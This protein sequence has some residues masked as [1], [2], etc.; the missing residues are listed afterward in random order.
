MPPSLYVAY[1]TSS[2][3][4]NGTETEVFVNT[5]KTLDGETLDFSNFSPFTR[6]II[7]ADPENQ[8]SQPE[9]IS[10]TGIDSTILAF[11]GITRGL[12]SINSS[13]IAANKVYHGTGTPV[14]ISWGAQNI[15]DLIA[16]VNGLVSGVNGNASNTVFGI[17]KLNKN[18]G[19]LPRAQASLVSQ[20]TSPNLTLKVSAFSM[21]G[22]NSMNVIYAGG[23][24]STITSPASNPRI[25][26]VV[27]NTDT[28]TLLLRTGVE[29]SSPLRPT[30]TTNDIVLAAIYNRVGETSIKENDDSTNGYILDWYEPSRFNTLINLNTAQATL[31]PDQNQS[32]Q[33]SSV[34]V[35][36]S[37]STTHKSILA[38]SFLPTT[39]GISAVKLFKYAD[40]GTF[41]GSVKVSIQ[42]S[43]SGSPSGT[44][45]ASYTISNAAWLKLN[46]SAEFTVSFSTE[47][48]SLSVGSVYWIVIT[49]STSDTSN[50]PNLGINTA[51]GYAGSLKYNNS[52]DGWIL[53]STSQLY[54]KEISGIV[55]KI[56]Q[57]DSTGLTP[58]NVRPYSLVSFDKTT[59]NIATTNA[60]TVLSKQL[61]GGFFGINTGIKIR[62]FGNISSTNTSTSSNLNILLK[63][64]G[65]SLSSITTGN[66]ENNSNGITGRNFYVDF[67]IVNQN[68][69]SSQVNIAQTQETATGVNGTGSAANLQDVANFSSG[70]STIDTSQPGLLE[71]IF[72]LSNATNAS[73]NYTGSIIEKIG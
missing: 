64:N 39:T 44:D 35:G 53:I 31:Y 8:A 63:Y 46:A 45:L 14:I 54:F 62:I 28:S 61:D 4:S 59:T 52:T 50:H 41:T 68:S 20:Q 2:L 69:L 70:T 19:T 7:V 36:E 37:N 67:I 65:V 71:I 17:T 49:P 38:Q 29:G 26:L 47:Y 22:D 73:V 30:P 5:L 33:N 18:L 40:T 58:A 3:A 9:I 24:T 13:S 27:Y 16:Y 32:T 55:N 48:E 60:T 6:G 42:A 57:T 21:T 66:V 15:S 43:T 34:S 72:T 23:N 56:V 1:L 12:S 25:D 11:T 51:G 10:F